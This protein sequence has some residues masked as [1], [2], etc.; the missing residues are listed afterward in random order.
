M[1][2][3]GPNRCDEEWLCAAD[4]VD[5]R[6]I[7]S[8][9]LYDPDFIQLS[10]CITTTKSDDDSYDPHEYRMFFGLPLV[11]ESS[12]REWDVG[13]QDAL[14]LAARNGYADVCEVLLKC[15]A[16]VNNLDD[17]NQS[18]LFLAAWKGQSIECVKV[19]LDCSATI[20]V[21]GAHEWIK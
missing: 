20:N 9:L 8:V 2:F 12:A 11:P 13:G 1:E 18:P 17:Y 5:V 14:L 16:D 15:R 21:T 4:D 3:L 7:S 19:L 6:S 10:N